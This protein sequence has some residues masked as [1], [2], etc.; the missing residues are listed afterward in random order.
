MGSCCPQC[1]DRRH[2]VLRQFVQ[3][4]AS[5][6]GPCPSCKALRACLL[7]PASLW[8][9][10]A[11]VVALYEP[12]S[13]VDGPLGSAPS[14]EG[15]LLAALLQRDFTV[16]S[17]EALPHAEALL[18]AILP[19]GTP[20][21]WRERTT[22][23]RTDQTTWGTWER[24]ATYLRHER[25]FYFDERVAGMADPRQWLPPLLP[26]LEYALAQG[27]VFFRGRSGVHSLPE[28]G[29]PP[30]ERAPAGRANPRG[31]P[32]LYLSTDE[33]TVIAELRPWKGQALTVAI[34]AL[35][36]PV[37]AVNLT[38]MPALASPFGPVDLEELV[39]RRAQYRLLEQVNQVISH[40]IDPQQ[41][42]LEYLPT[43]Y[44]TEVIRQAGYDGVLFNSAL[45]PGDNLVLF[46]PEQAEAVS[47]RQVSVTHI[48]YH[49]QH[50]EA[51]RPQAVNRSS[52]SLGI[53]LSTAPQG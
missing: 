28:M 23:A 5:A 34:F 51:A 9:L 21:R 52:D 39:Q 20:T 31:I 13:G 14:V 11:P 37:R 18:E 46:R 2:L 45:G 44:V 3:A 15:A 12:V 36:E 19:A 33:A 32:F 26:Q 1:F 38:Q 10:F 24:F 47:A 27:Q 40:P 25:R 16:F 48:H 22:L 30:P 43:Q 53:V 4:Q 8:P 6:K 41:A 49:W 50:A 29:A 17:A 35:R 42:E 7:D